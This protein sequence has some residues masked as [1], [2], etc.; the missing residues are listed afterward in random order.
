MNR[1]ELANRALA[2]RALRELITQAENE[3][4]EELAEAFQV[5]GTREMGQVGGR[6]IGS[7]QLI[8]GTSSWAVAD[9]EA[10]LRWVKDN[11]PGELVEVVRPSYTTAMLKKYKDGGAMIDEET[12]EAIVP[13]GIVPKSG[14]PSIRVSASK[15]APGIILQ[16]M[17]DA[18][19]ILGLAVPAELTQ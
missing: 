12:G 15:D 5:P 6:V 8:K 19:V 14:Q 4:R 16:A 17:G 18:A 7:V 13:D 2:L 3:V 10:W 9:Y 11:N 1:E